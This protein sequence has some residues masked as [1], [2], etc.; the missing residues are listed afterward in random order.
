[1]EATGKVGSPV[2]FQRGTSNGGNIS[3]KERE[4]M[5]MAKGIVEG[6]RK[7]GEEVAPAGEK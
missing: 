5:A 1:M 7:T 2:K 4:V 3:K 6:G